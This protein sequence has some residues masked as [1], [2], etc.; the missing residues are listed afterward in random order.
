MLWDDHEVKNNWYPGMSLDADERYTV[1]DSRVLAANARRAFL[2]YSPIRLSGNAAARRFTDRAPTARCSRCSRS[3]FGRI[4]DPNT[5]NRQTVAR[6]RDGA[7]GR[8]AACVAEARAAI[9][10]AQRGK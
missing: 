3:I 5:S 10:N 1:K 8:P 4:A 6:R 7:C 2:E 9:V